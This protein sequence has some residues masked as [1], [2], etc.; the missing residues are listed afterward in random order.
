MNHKLY[1]KVPGVLM[2]RKMSSSCDSEKQT[3]ASGFGVFPTFFTCRSVI[4]PVGKN[5]TNFKIRD[6]MIVEPERPCEKC[7]VCGRGRYNLCGEMKIS[8]E[9]CY[10]CKVCKNGDL[11]LCHSCHA[12]KTWNSPHWPLPL[13]L[14]R[15]TTWPGRRL[16]IVLASQEGPDDDS[17]QDGM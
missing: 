8:G 1:P 4:S 16:R 17:P 3:G 9:F 2:S 7:I 5:V 6:R 12:K 13:C 15:K 14:I 10:W 11:D